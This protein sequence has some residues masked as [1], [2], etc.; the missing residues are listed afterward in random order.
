VIHLQLNYN[1]MKVPYFSFAITLEDL[2]SDLSTLD[3]AADIAAG[4]YNPDAVVSVTYDPEEDDFCSVEFTDPPYATFLGRHDISLAEI[5]ELAEMTAF[6]I[7]YSEDN[8]EPNHDS[9]KIVHDYDTAL[10]YPE[11]RGHPKKCSWQEAH[12]ARSYTKIQKVQVFV[13]RDMLFVDRTE[14]IGEP[15]YFKA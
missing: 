13:R 5:A 12:K 8:G 4:K 9:L 10:F 14:L 2:Q 11:H 7:V 3:I 1:D 6:Y 15:E